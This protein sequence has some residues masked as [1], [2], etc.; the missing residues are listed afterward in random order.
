MRRFRVPYLLIPCVQVEF[1]FPVVRYTKPLPHPEILDHPLGQ[2]PLIWKQLMPK[3][4]DTGLSVP[5]KGRSENVVPSEFV[6]HP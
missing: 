3:G 5:G 6:N 2:T 1:E 4:I